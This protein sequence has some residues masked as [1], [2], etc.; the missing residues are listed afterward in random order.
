MMYEVFMPSPLRLMRILRP[1]LR[2]VIS[3]SSKA[4]A[5]SSMRCPDCASNWMPLSQDSFH[6]HL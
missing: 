4:S 6:E 1:V 5:M 2:S 3:P